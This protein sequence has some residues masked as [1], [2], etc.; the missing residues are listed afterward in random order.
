MFKTMQRNSQRR[1]DAGVRA[2]PGPR[3][4]FRRERQWAERRR[5]KWEKMGPMQRLKATWDD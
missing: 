4:M 1:A 5:R 2:F 3:P